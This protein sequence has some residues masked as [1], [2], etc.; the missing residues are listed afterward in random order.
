MSFYAFNFSFYPQIVY[1]QQ[2][3]NRW[4]GDFDIWNS[5]LQEYLTLSISNYS[6]SP[7]SLNIENAKDWINALFWIFPF[8]YIRKQYRNYINSVDLDNVTINRS[9]IQL[10][11]DNFF[12]SWTILP[13]KLCLCQ[14]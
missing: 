10:F 5:I 14:D 13:E 3:I 11:F 1:L 9:N 8:Y 2:R 6:N 7:T 12:N 4:K